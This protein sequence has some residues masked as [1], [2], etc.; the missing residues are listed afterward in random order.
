MPY[1]GF[2]ALVGKTVVDIAGATVGSES[3]VFTTDDGEMFEMYHSNDCCESVEVEDIDGDMADLIGSPIVIA[4]ESES[5]NDVTP[6][7][8]PEL[9][10]ES[11]TWTFYRIATIK[12]WVVIRWYGSSNGYYSESVSFRQ[13]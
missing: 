1:L 4:D 2:D 12:G 5:D 11:F 7:G 8:C 13:V 3:I 6:P 9:G 10:D